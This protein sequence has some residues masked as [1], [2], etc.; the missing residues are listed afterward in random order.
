M[1]EPIK[2]RGTVT[3][4][5]YYDENSFWG[6]FLVR[7]KEN[8]LHSEKVT[9]PNVFEDDE[10]FEP[11]Y[12]VTVAGKVQQLYVGSEYE[13]IANE[14]YN[15]R[16]MSWQYEPVTVTAIAPSSLESSKL[17]LSSILTENQASVLLKEYPNIIQE[18]IDGKDNVDTSKLK[19]IGEKS[20]KNIKEKIIN[21][22]VI[23]DIITMLQPYG[24]TYS[25]IKSLLKWEPNSSILKQK[26]KENPYE[27][28]HAKGFGFLKVDKLALK[29][30]PELIDSGKRLFAFI[31]YT[32]N[33]EAEE[34]GNT[35]MSFTDLNN[36][37]IDSIPQCKDL[38]DNLV[39]QKE[40]GFFS[41]FF[42]IDN[43]KI[44][45]KKYWDCENAIYDILK[46][47]ELYQF[48]GK[49][50]VSAGIEKAEKQFGYELS[51]DQ[52]NV[53]RQVE[54]SNVVIFTG[55][56]GCV[57]ADTEFFNGERWKKISEYEVGDSVLQWDKDGTA[58][59]IKPL[60]YIKKPC[61]YLYHFETKYG[62][63][64]TLSPD[65]NCCWYSP[66]GKFYEGT[67]EEI[68][69]MQEN[70]HSGFTGKFITTF[71]YSGSGVNL[72]DEMLRLYAAVIADGSFYNN[73]QPDWDS[74][75]RV[76]FHLKKERKKERIQKL[77]KEA[78]LKCRVASSA[79][80]GYNDFY[81]DVPFR[82]KV[83]P[84]E[85]YAC[86]THQLEVIAQESLYW[87]GSFSNG[88]RTGTISTS[89][90]ENADF[91]QFAFS[92]NGYRVSIRTADRSG[93]KYT[94]CG[95][96]YT[97]K[98][99]EYELVISKRTLT[100][101][102]KPIDDSGP[103]KITKF[104]PSDGFQYCFTVPSHFLILRRNNRIFV[105][106]NCGK[107]TTARAILNSF[108]NSSI[109]C[110]SLSAK[111]A[112]RIQEATGFKATTAHRMLGA[113][114]EGFTY[115]SENR[116]SYDVI[117]IDEASMLNCSL[118]YHII[119]AVKEGAKVIICGDHAQLPPIGAG[120]VFSDL[121]HM[122]D[123]FNVSVLTKVHR[124]AEKSGILTDANKI[125]KG[126]FPIE[127][128][129]PQILSGELK[130]MAYVF[131]DIKERIQDIAVKQFLRAV[132]SKGLDNV[133][134]I[135]PRKDIVTN[136]A[137]ELNKRIQAELIDTNNAHCIQGL[138]NKFYV[139]DR[140]IQIEND[141]DRDVF[142]GEVGYV[143]DVYPQAKNNETIMIVRF[144]STLTSDDKLVEYTRDDLKTVLLGYAT[145]CHKAQ[146]S[147]YD[148][149]IVVI[150]NTHF[151]L[152]DNCLLYTAITRAKKM[153]ILIAQPEAFNRAMKQ[154]FNRNRQTW[155]RLKYERGELK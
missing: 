97:R 88:N 31:K 71:K 54:N 107:S 46:E 24:V 136:S 106:G 86:T 29:I 146:G 125:R 4:Q 121:L 17:F 70:K 85:W 56:A 79:A 141:A 8:L 36:R 78:G 18:I 127:E 81:T 50:D 9:N 115:T 124:Q 21:N 32:L 82:T 10:D 68:K 62:L 131:R 108:P 22:Y 49:I 16:Y 28:T 143:E 6:V 75:N 40:S 74:Y 23:S 120:N 73:V 47:L 7:T 35:W 148:Y 142:N 118:F 144:K 98:S 80:E 44:G 135:V 25:A 133:S 99:I 153:C 55:N 27:L 5:R 138:L 26:I 48:S 69:Q 65:H 19:G 60:A 84:K 111:A 145:T 52:K 41:G 112:Q 151:T 147:E 123:D 104:V 116:M 102:A 59:L 3:F 72:T 119:S 66:K 37:I 83:F 20:Y 129:K 132:E 77:I 103:T 109:A 92:A 38:F 87:D 117:F 64:Q 57:D 51:E 12:I 126:I 11:H 96:I 39:E 155:L 110:C 2:F 93:Q 139:G 13:F 1:A 101:F 89:I 137:L 114:R 94:T 100:G 30:Q 61:D 34:N 149:V 58:T 45:L 67:A 63:N 43:N 90:K 53:V 154:N 76:R 105:T 95:K 134:C 42:F 14:V 122:K 33:K 140:V 152:L 91:L 113:S 15:T 150:D 128:P 130:D